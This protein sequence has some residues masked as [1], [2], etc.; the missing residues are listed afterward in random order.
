VGEW[1]SVGVLRIRARGRV[2]LTSSCLPGSFSLIHPPPPHTPSPLQWI[3]ISPLLR[4]RLFCI[5]RHER[6]RPANCHTWL[7]ESMGFETQ[8]GAAADGAGGTW[9]A[10]RE[11][12]IQAAQ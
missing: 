5:Q 2:A 4:L 3:L 11:Q 1:G 6:G 7:L 9:I 10:L 12:Q 8:S